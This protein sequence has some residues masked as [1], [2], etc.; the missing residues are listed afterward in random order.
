V[1]IWNANEILVSTICGPEEGI[2]LHEFAA[3]ETYRLDLPKI[4]LLP[5]V[6]RIAVFVFS[7]EPEPL[8]TM[9]NALSFEVCQAPISDG[10]ASYRGDHGIYRAATSMTRA[11]T[12]AL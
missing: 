8:L 2:A 5:G 10:S 6:Y 4:S 11:T 7:D 1:K 9:E 3:S 12:F